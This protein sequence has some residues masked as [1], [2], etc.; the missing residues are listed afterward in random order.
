MGYGLSGAIG[1]ALASPG[2]RTIHVEGDGGF[3][4]N[5]QEMATVRVNNLPIKTFLFSNEGYASIRMTQRNYF[6]G[7]Y[8]GCD[9]RTGLGFPDWELLAK[10][11][12]IPYLELTAG[13]DTPGFDALFTAGGP[14]FFTVPVDPE[15]TY[16]PK[17][18]SRVTESGSMESNPLHLMSPALPSDVA[19]RV[20]PF[21]DQ[22]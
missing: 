17:I 22:H 13:L 4:Q 10:A 11:F 15:Q 9:V 8:L 19:D 7:A 6:D 5:L 3:L 18:T 1:A 12:G 16:Y 20:L 14:A 21:L 2:T